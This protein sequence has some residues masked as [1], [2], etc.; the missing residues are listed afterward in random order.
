MIDVVIS[1]VIYTAVLLGCYDGDTCKINSEAFVPFT[2][3]S[4][5]L[6]GFDTPEIR[7]KC[8]EEKEIA[9][10]AKHFTIKYMET[11]EVVYVS[12]KRDKYGRLITTVPGLAEALIAADLARPYDGGKRLPWCD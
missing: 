8:D 9:R 1:G 4:L 5:R 7:G 2:E 6:E 12:E 11:V 3:Y 10:K